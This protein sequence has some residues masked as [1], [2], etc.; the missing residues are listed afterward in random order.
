[1]KRSHLSIILLSFV[2]G[3]C[4][5]PPGRGPGDQPVFVVA[6]ENPDDQ[7][8]VQ[9]ENGAARI[10]IS[11]PTGIGSA[12]LVLESGAMPEAMIVRFHL[13][14]LEQIRFTSAKDQIAASFSSS[15]V[16]T[17]PDQM[18]IS[19]GNEIPILPGQPL[20][21]KIEIVSEQAEKI[22]PLEEGFFEVTLPKEFLQKAG[23]SFTIEWIDFYR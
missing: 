13:R 15:E 17:I 20:W 11:S 16:V 1:M 9:N 21:M 6:T 12:D 23:T 2:L 5:G 18:K 7:V 4:S 14:G 10:D 22:I 19:E 3:A 8:S